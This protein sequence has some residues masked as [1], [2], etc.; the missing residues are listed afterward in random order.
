MEKKVVSE[1][2]AFEYQ[3][4]APLHVREARCEIVGT[5]T[6]HDIS[7]ANPAFGRVSAYLLEPKCGD[8]VPAIVFLH[9]GQGDRSTFLSEAL[10]YAEAGVESLLIDES[11][12]SHFLPANPTGP[13]G[14]RSYIIQCVTDLR[15]GVDLLESRE[16]VDRTRIGYVGYSLGASVGGQFAGVEKLVKAHVLMAGFPEASRGW[17]LHAPSEDFREAVAPLDGVQYVG[18]AAPASLLFQWAIRDEIVSKKDL[19]TFFNAASEPKEKRWYD[20]DHSFNR[21]ALTDRAQWLG[22]E[23]DLFSPNP[24][25]LSRVHLPQR[26][27]EFHNEARGWF[28]TIR[29]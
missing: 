10:A 28:T 25:R 29:R 1:P 20:A 5:A 13:D 11:R 18:N 17:A 9:W 22:S 8:P 3:R 15:R 12:M 16:E 2:D 24:G 21:E 23:L 26:D 6:I 7:Y 19:E 27:L 14:A 4:A